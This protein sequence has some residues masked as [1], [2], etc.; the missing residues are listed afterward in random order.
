MKKLAY[1]LLLLGLNTLC[2]NITQQPKKRL[3]D[4]ASN[5]YSQ[6]GE[7]GIIQKIFE[8][9]GTTNK[10]CIEFGAWDGFHLSNTA[11][12]WVN[13]GWK[14]IL[15]ELDHKRFIELQKNV[16]AYNCIAINARVGINEN[17]LESI[18]KRHEIT[19]ES[20][21]LLS[22]DIDGD[23]YYVFESLTILKPRVII[24]EYNPTFPLEL[25][26]YPELG[27]YMGCSLASLIRMGTSKGYRL[28]ATTPANAFFVIEEEYEKFASFDTE[29]LH[30]L[31]NEPY[32]LYL[33]TSYAGEYAIIGKNNYTP[34][35]I[36]RPYKNN[37]RGTF[38]R[39]H[40]LK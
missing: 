19:E 15:I 29:I 11:N 2:D 24:C 30:I 39:F 20:I 31:T 17:S 13:Q 14:S 1:F 10:I 7:D 6:F 37:L 32:L 18:L 5:T 9:I 27:N 4:F 35:G 21:D 22:I 38:N 12:L 28:V 16:A 36:N 3:L 34:Y 8:V 40:T 26:V 25:D 33:V 23:D